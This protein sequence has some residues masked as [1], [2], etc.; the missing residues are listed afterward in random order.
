MSQEIEILEKKIYTNKPF[1]N[2]KG[3]YN[4]GRVNSFDSFKIMGNHYLL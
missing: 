3:Q 1:E 2:A 4:Y